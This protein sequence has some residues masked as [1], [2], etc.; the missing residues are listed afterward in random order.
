MQR[1][2]TTQQLQNAI[3]NNLLIIKKAECS[4]K[5]SSRIDE[6]NAEKFKNDFDFLCESGLFAESLGWHYEKDHESGEYIL[7]TGRYNPHSEII[8][9]VYLKACENV[10]DED[11]EKALFFQED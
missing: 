2:T 7:Q 1:R 6:I 5:S 9:A 8:I 10:S 11:I 4:Y 3:K